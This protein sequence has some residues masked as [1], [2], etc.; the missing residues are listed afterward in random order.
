MEYTVYQLFNEFQRF[1]KK[2]SYDSWFSAKLAGAEG[3]QDV[4]NWLSDEEIVET[5]PKSNRIEF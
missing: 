4:P 2:Y 5:R 3:L 1:E